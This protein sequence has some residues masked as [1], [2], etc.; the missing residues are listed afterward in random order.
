[1]SLRGLTFEGLMKGVTAKG[2]RVSVGGRRFSRIELVLSLAVVA[3]VAATILLV[4]AAPRKSVLSSARLR[5]RTI[6]DQRADETLRARSSSLATRGTTMNG[7]EAVPNV[8][9][10]PNAPPTESAPIIRHAPLAAPAPC[11]DRDPEHSRRRAAYL[12][13]FRSLSGSHSNIEV[14]P[15]APAWAIELLS[16]NPEYATRQVNRSLGL[17]GELPQIFLYSTPELLR[18]TTCLNG[19]AVAYYD[20][21][22]HLAVNSDARGYLDLVDGLRHEYVHHLFARNAIPAPT[23]FEEGEALSVESTTHW[24]LSPPPDSRERDGR[25][26]LAECER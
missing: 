17:H 24:E 19:L 6:S 3:I 25:R 8:P 20:G 14:D 4:C 1:M 18:D 22:I 7:L 9:I 21:A 10:I 13:T 26:T 16:S 23:W 2:A 12:S 11:A 15:A 5:A